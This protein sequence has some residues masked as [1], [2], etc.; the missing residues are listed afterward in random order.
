[1]ETLKNSIKEDEYPTFGL[2]FEEG[3][4]L[5]GRENL[6]TLPISEIRS[7]V[8]GI[9]DNL[10]SDQN[11]FYVIGVFLKFLSELGFSIRETLEEDCD[12][13]GS[14]DLE[15]LQITVDFNYG[16]DCIEYSCVF[17]DHR[18]HQNV[19]ENLEGGKGILEALFSGGWSLP[20]FKGLLHQA[21]LCD[22]LES[23]IYDFRQSWVRYQ[24]IVKDKIIS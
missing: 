20:S 5:E 22:D 8:R 3:I 17:S 4:S 23:F 24:E 7:G 14:M 11:T 12:F 21:T 16:H 10:L 15:H 19:E 6:T 9:S 2:I 18:E 13:E 1:V